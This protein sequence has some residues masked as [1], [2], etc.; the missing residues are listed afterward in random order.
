M[1]QKNKACSHLLLGAWGVNGTE[2]VLDMPQQGEDAGRA[3]VLPATQALSFAACAGLSR[4]SHA[5]PSCK[6]FISKYQGSGD[7]IFVFKKQNSHKD[8][9]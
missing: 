5:H 6:Y 9:R 1:M 7:L 3:Q 4:F 2:T 8:K